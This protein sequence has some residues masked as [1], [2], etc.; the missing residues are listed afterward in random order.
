MYKSRSTW[1]WTQACLGNSSSSLLASWSQW[2][3]VSTCY[4]IVQ[5]WSLKKAEG[6]QLKPCRCICALEVSTGRRAAAASHMIS[7]TRTG[8]KPDLDLSSRRCCIL[9]RGYKLKTFCCTGKARSSGS[10]G[11]SSGHVPVT[12]SRTGCKPDLELSSRLYYLGAA[13]IRRCALSATG[14]WS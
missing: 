3:Q 10:G 14:L 5:S 12:W 6:L 13:S 8:C 11:C 4:S 9:I 2:I 1:S 7:E